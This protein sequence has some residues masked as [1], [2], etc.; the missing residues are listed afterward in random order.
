MAATVR[1]RSVGEAEYRYNQ[2]L[3]G[4]KDGVNTTFMTPEK[5]R[6]L[7][8]VTW[9]GRELDEGAD[10]TKSESGGAGT[11]FDTLELLYTKPPIS[12][13]VL[14]ASYIVF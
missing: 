11:G 1:K 13:S 10:F 2:Y 3:V 5:F 8:Q 6:T 12:T 4:T 9:N 7:L 14:K